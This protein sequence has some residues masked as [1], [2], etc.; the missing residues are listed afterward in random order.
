VQTQL[1]SNADLALAFFSPTAAGQAA[2]LSS[3]SA[4]LGGGRGPRCQGESIVATTAK[5][6]PAPRWF[7]WLEPLDKQIELMPFI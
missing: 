4:A 5:S 2:E 1:G 3:T 6:K 7:L